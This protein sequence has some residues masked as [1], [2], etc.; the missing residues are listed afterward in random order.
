MGRI[1]IIVFCTCET[2]TRI[3]VAL[4]DDSKSFC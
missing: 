3:V 1:A 4:E 2:I